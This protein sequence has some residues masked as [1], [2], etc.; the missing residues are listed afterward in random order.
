MKKWE[1]FEP[2]QYS[3]TDKS[4]GIVMPSYNRMTLAVTLTVVAMVI[5]GVI[6]SIYAANYTYKKQ[7]YPNGDGEDV[8]FYQ[9]TD[10]HGGYTV[11]GDKFEILEFTETVQRGNRATLRIQGEPNTEYDI[12][13][14]LKSGASTNSALVPK[15]SDGKGVV[16]WDWKVYK[17]TSVGRF[18]VVVKS[19]YGKNI[20]AS[21]AEL[22]LTITD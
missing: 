4:H 20:C 16:E 17:G 14:Y 11:I 22:Y 3:I 1:N 19:T 18:K 12:T 9:D 2:Y 21:Y 5:C 13:V 8:A 6:I 10:S 15:I 7:Y